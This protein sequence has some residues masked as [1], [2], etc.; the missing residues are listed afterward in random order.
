M[1]KKNFGVQGKDIELICT[2]NILL[3][4]SFINKI[5]LKKYNY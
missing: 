2:P 1:Y 5:V 4:V 3:N